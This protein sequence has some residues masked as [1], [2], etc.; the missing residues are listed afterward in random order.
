MSEEVSG[1]IQSENPPEIAVV[2]KDFLIVGIGASAGGIKALKEFFAQ[3]PADSG[4]AYVV[5][6]HLSP[7]HDSQLAAILQTT[8]AIPVAQVTEKVHLEPNHVYVVPPDKSLRMLDGSIVV[9]DITR[10][11]ERRAPVDI[12]FRTLAE[13]HDSRAVAVILSGTGANGSMGVKRIKE[14]GGVIFVQNPKEAEYED[15]PRHSLATGL[16]DDVLPVADIPAKIISYRSNL[17][18]IQIPPETETRSEID[19]RALREIFTQLRVKTGHD[20]SNYKRATVLRRIE[21]R[22]NVRELKGLFEYADL[23]R[24]EPE[25]TDALLRD[26]LI[27]VTNFFRDRYAFDALETTVLPKILEGKTAADTVRVW[28]AGCATGEEAYS[29]AMLLAEKT[30]EISDAPNIQ[31]FATDIDEKAIAFARDGLYTLNDA[32]DVSPERLRQFFIKEAEGY[33]VRSEIREMI[34]FAAHN[35]IKDAPF[36]HLDLA[37][38]RN[39]LIYLNRTAQSRVMEVVHFALNPNGYFFL[40]SS[41]S[42]DGA[43]DLFTPIDKE[44][45]I[46]QSRPVTTRIAL[47]LPDLPVTFRRSVQSTVPTISREQENRMLER[48]SYADLHQQLLEQYAPPSV[49]VNEEYDILH[50]SERAGRYLQITGGE[51]TFN[52]LKVV[53]QD[54]RLELRTALYQ[55]IQR[56]TNV[57]ALNLPVVI[58][59]RTEYVNLHI[60][61]SLR[62]EDATRGFI[63]VIFERTERES[64]AAQP[65]EILGSSQPVALQLEEELM[66]TKAQLR[67]TTEQ[68]EVQT[69][70]Y[71][72][73]NEE[74]QAMNEELRSAAEEL[75]TGKEELQSLNEELFTVNQELK[76]KIE[77]VS[78]SNNDFRN[79]INSTDIGTVFLDRSLR[80]S[81]FSPAVRSIF[82]LIPADLGRS[83]SDITNRLEDSDLTLDVE[84][85]LENLRIVEREVRTVDERTFLMRILPYRTAE[86][87]ISGV[88]LTF[89]DLTRRVR[90]E[91]S[92]R[93][94]AEFN[95]TVLDSLP[96][97]TAVLDRDGA[98][99]A[100]NESWR[101]FARENGGSQLDR[102]DVGVNYLQICRHSENMSADDDSTAFAGIKSVLQGER[103]S[104]A[105]EYPCHSPDRQRWFLL[106]V[107]PLRSADGGAVISHFEITDRRSAENNLRLSEENLRIMVESAIDYAIV[108]IDDNGSVNLWNAGAE[109]IYGY[110]AAEMVGQPLDILFTPEARAA[111]LPERELRQARLTGRS[112]EEK[113]AHVRKDGTRFFASGSI[114]PLKNGTAGG[115]VKICRDITSKL[116]AERTLNEKAMLEKLVHAQEG[117]RKRIARDLHDHL[118]QQLTGLRM[119]LEAAH[120]ICEDE[121]D[122]CVHITEIQRI[123]ATIDADLDF[124]AWELRPASLDDLGLVAAM[125]DYVREWRKHSGVTAE[126]HTTGLNV[127]KLSPEIEMNI[128]RIA[129]EALNNIW[130]HA[131]AKQV[132]VIIKRQIADVLMIIEDDGIGFDSQAQSESGSLGLIGMNERAVLIGGTIEIES[133]AGS[134]TTVF[135]HVPF[136]GTKRD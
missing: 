124:L 74:L 37:T 79:L 104:F 126:F 16:V 106:T 28:V 90:A 19:E 1:N 33:R 57:E 8:A 39:L 35:L 93:E 50:L 77:E 123:A 67:M 127:I 98:I 11:E 53:R 65:T 9:S 136:D 71:K 26:L 13:S 32:A 85:V 59:D 20:F 92:L 12:F 52:L 10:V 96:A 60:R 34:L 114:L 55:S 38:C 131:Q 14:K 103:S 112:D 70:E 81:L 45:H 46:F 130:K 115:F 58:D 95:T 6:L 101:Q 134:G 61:P 17:G 62:S 82:N 24:E 4:M 102:T 49:I 133:S 111:K 63:L 116:D 132:S 121:S 3:V 27:S 31:I 75:E 51:P 88:V 64:E 54:L 78:Q 18:K 94:S 86:D 84:S 56:R 5:I 89:V 22:I 125:S 29:L 128:Y 100:V 30:A 107:T 83:L 129:Q 99:R 48:L 91:T 40:G 44:N 69:E 41:E 120:R 109:R 110:T 15:M 117:E 118:G 25:E 42:I 122:L 68:Y 73:S 47:P 76:I 105:L 36:S 2:P 113:Q 135:L 72:A 80:V 21:R 43:N 87:R 108:T 97:Q 7:D 119:K 23:M 66:R